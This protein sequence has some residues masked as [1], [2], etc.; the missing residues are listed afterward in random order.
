[1]Q[2]G[3]VGTDHG[4]AAALGRPGTRSGHCCFEQWQGNNTQ[5]E[6]GAWNTHTQFKKNGP[7]RNEHKRKKMRQALDYNDREEQ[8]QN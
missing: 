3:S 8:K 6:K 2:G 7:L 5:T 1:V 4:G